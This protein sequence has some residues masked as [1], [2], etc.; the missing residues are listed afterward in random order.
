[1]ENF[2]L[3][4]AV[5]NTVQV[6]KKDHQEKNHQE[7]NPIKDEEETLTYAA[8]SPDEKALVEA[9]NRFGISVIDSSE[10][11]CDIR[12]GDRVRKYKKLEIFP[13]DSS[14][15]RMSVVVED[16]EGK[17]SL[18]CKGAD[19]EMRRLLATGKVN[20]T[21][22][23]IDEYAGH[24]LRTLVVASR[25]V[26]KDEYESAKKEIEEARQSMEDRK[27]AVSR[28]QGEMEMNLNLL[29]ATAVEDRL[30]DGVGETIQDLKEAGIKVW[31]LTGDKLETALSVAYS[32][33]LI[34]NTMTRLHLSRQS[35][36]DACGETV[37]RYAT[38]V[39]DIDP[40]TESGQRCAL[41]VDGR[42]LHFA[43]KFHI[44]KFRLVCERCLIVLCCR[45]SPIQKAEVVHMI[46]VSKNSPVTAA[47]GDGANDVS[48]IQEAHVGFGLMGKE[49]RQA[50][51][52]ADFAF[53]RFR[54]LK[55]VL[56]VHG[57]LFYNR[58]STLIHYFFYKNVAFVTPQFLY[59]FYNA[60]SS[61]VRTC[62][63]FDTCSIF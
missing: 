46:K 11:T 39:Q 61:Q 56:L 8:D 24:G 16:E 59:S 40:A 28:A 44:D 23:H 45:M 43:L 21:Y 4:I 53:S 22:Q 20:E 17:M 1:M 49:G 30:Q 37:S 47:I 48:M 58:V 63:I 10:K 3:A 13:F 19:S 57:N 14:R 38:I 55:R 29:G 41:I 26:S 32:C 33:G 34:D 62:I 36:P 50:V 12:V 5:C 25:S 52:A 31:L 9:C 54:F 27:E 51:N 35:N 6:E 2:L 7:K 42:S 15:K 60:F 18:V